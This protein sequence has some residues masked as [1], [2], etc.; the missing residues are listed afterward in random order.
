MRER[1]GAAQILEQALG[2]ARS[3]QKQP[4][5]PVVRGDLVRELLDATGDVLLAEER[6]ALA[7]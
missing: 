7:R 3:E 1:Q 6:L 5:P 4:S 2:T